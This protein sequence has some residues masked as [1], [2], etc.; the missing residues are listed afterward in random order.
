MN[1]IDRARQYNRT[2]QALAQGISDESV[3]ARIP[4]VYPLWQPQRLYQFGEYAAHTCGDQ[5][6]NQVYKCLQGHLS[7]SGWTPDTESALWKRVGYGQSDLEMW[8]QPLGAFDAYNSGDRISHN[9]V[10][11]IST[12]DGNVWEP[13]VYGWEVDIG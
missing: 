10:A 3:V 11:Y 1:L 6:K 2:L 4:D 7:Q 12:L 5:S 9:G 8:V 13:G